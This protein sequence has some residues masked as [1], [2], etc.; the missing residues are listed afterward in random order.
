MHSR[1]DEFGGISE[2]LAVLVSAPN[3]NR[4]A[5]ADINLV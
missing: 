5:G 2:Q 3:W 4:R 1:Q